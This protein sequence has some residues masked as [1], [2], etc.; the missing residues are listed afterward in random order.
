MTWPTASAFGHRARAAVSET[1]ATERFDVRSA[2]VNARPRTTA[3]SSTLKYSGETNLYA[4][5]AFAPLVSANAARGRPASGHDAA[6]AATDGSAVTACT[7]ALRV[8][9]FTIW[10]TTVS[11]V[12]MPE[13]NVAAANALLKNT[14]AEISS[15]ADALT[16]RPIRKFRA[17]PGRASLTTSPRIVLIGSMRV[18]CSAG[19]SPK[20]IVET[21]APTMRNSSTRQSASGTDNRISPRSG[22]M[23][24]IT[25]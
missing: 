25:A 14:A 16:C 20:T 9:S 15:S 7:I 1:M 17:R 8:G 2:G 12:R 13:S 6:T 5:A 22:A 24:V 18:A 4:T 11:E 21:P 10:T 19:A 3:I 23:L